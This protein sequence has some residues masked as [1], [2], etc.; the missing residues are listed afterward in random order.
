MN[1]FPNGRQSPLGMFLDEQRSD[2]VRSEIRADAL[3]PDSVQPVVVGICDGKGS[4]G[5]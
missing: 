1:H 3:N 5:I 4:A 2:G